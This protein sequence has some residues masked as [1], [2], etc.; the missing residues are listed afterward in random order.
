MC[1]DHSEFRMV[2]LVTGRMWVAQMRR[3]L[4]CLHACCGLALTCRVRWRRFSR[5]QN[6]DS[7]LYGRTNRVLHRYQFGASCPGGCGCAPW[8]CWLQWRRPFS[9][10][11]PGPRQGCASSFTVG[12]MRPPCCAGVRPVAIPS[13][14]SS[15]PGTA[16]LGQELTD[17][18]SSTD[19]VYL[20]IAVYEARQRRVLRPS[21]Q[22]PF[23]ASAIATTRHALPPHRDRRSVRARPAAPARL[24]D[25]EVDQQV[26]SAT[27]VMFCS[28]NRMAL[29]CSLGR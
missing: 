14:P 22:P 13:R 16:I 27:S 26:S 5:S 1:T 23:P 8:G 7:G 15:P 10:R 12:C 20:A 6:V 19:A 18:M 9:R 2:G 25:T 11:V 28:A 24:R 17:S 3:S 4:S 29:K 21:A